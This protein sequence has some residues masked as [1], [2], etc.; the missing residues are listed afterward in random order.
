M[1]P[2]WILLELRVME[3]VV[4]TG[5][6]KMCKAP[7]KMSPSTNQHPVFTVWML[8]LSPNQQYQSTKDT[9]RENICLDK[10]GKLCW[11][12][13]HTRHNSSIH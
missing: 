4:T 7:V 10:K 12:K 1:S 9:I 8:F 6:N 11:L 3:V 2:F 13:R 5:A